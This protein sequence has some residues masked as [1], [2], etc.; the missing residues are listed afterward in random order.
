MGAEVIPVAKRKV[1]EEGK[2]TVAN[3][4]ANGEGTIFQ[5]QSGP[6]KGQYCAQI[7]IGKYPNGKPKRKSFYGKTRTEVKRKLGAY[8]EQHNRGIK[9]EVADH[10]NFGEYV[11]SFLELYKKP[12]LSLRTYEDYK[13]I[14]N[15]HIIP[16]L[17]DY[18]L[19][20]LDADAIQEFYLGLKNI[21]NKETLAP[22]TI[23]KI[24]TIINQTLNNAIEKRLISWNPDKITKRPPVKNRKGEAM[25][26]D[27][28]DKFLDAIDKLIDRWKAIFYLLLGTGL[29][30]GEALALKWPDLHL[31]KEGEEYV[32][33]SKS[34]S[35]TKAEGLKEKSPKNKASNGQ[36]PLPKM[37]VEALKQHKKSQLALAMKRGP[38]FQNKTP[39][40]HPI[41]VFASKAGTHTWPRNL[42]RKYYEVLDNAG[43]PRIK[44]HSLR[45]TFATKLIEEGEDIRVV[46]ELLRH[47]DIRTT[48]NIYSHVTPKTKKRASNKMEDILRRKKT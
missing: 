10:T 28:L 22:A 36:V 48:G 12:T 29:R 9:V 32:D 41:Y 11:L 37:A 20:D 24:H 44:L 38:K 1:D 23:S 14:I 42:A 40:G 6:K 17:G 18:Y 45:H 7:P 15:G 31:E 35:V 25:P 47:A 3:K 39:D 46:Q 30:E 4:N 27:S 26:D 13:K 16:K 21:K 2:I 19:P 8:M 33:V 5:V 43:I 34:L